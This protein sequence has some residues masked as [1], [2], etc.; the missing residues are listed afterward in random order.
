M[1]A[2]SDPRY[3]NDFEKKILVKRFGDKIIQFSE[4]IDRIYNHKQEIGEYPILNS[5]EAMNFFRVLPLLITKNNLENI[6]IMGTKDKLSK[7]DR[8]LIERNERKIELLDEFSLGV[9]SLPDCYLVNDK[10]L[11]G[12]KRFLRMVEDLN[13][14]CEFWQNISVS[15]RSEIAVDMCLGGTHYLGIDNSSNNRLK[16]YAKLTSLIDN[17]KSYLCIDSIESDDVSRQSISHWKSDYMDSDLF[18]LIEGALTVSRIFKY[19]GVIFRAPEAGQIA[20]LFGLPQRKF[21]DH[22]VSQFP[23]YCKAGVKIRSGAKDLY[24]APGFKDRFLSR[25]IFPFSSSALEEKVEVF[26]KR[27]RLNQIQGAYLDVSKQILDKY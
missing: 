21:K 5:D 4:H 2:S 7:T 25:S 14:E 24:R 11:N 12:N 9:N 1:K 15:S 20:G 10:D 27:K 13:W 26:S 18:S 17:N 3:R 6:L 8:D 16:A 19:D 22:K 23:N